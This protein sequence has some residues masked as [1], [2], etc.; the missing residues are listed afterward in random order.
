[1]LGLL[2]YASY[3]MSLT[4]LLFFFYVIYAGIGIQLFAGVTTREC[5]ETSIRLATIMH[6][7]R[8]QIAKSTGNPLSGFV[9]NQQAMTNITAL[10]IEGLHFGECPPT[11]SCKS[12]GCFVVPNEAAG[13]RTDEVYYFGFDNIW[14]A[15]LTQIVVTSLDEWPALAHP[16][17]NSGS[18]YAFLSWPFYASLSLLANS[19]STPCSGSR[20]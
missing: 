4:L 17:T 7:E 14:T 10:G 18:T 20:Y 1:M 12:A 6:K 16:L 13:D 5:P 8:H 2:A 3:A 15:L 19:D 9:L 11:L